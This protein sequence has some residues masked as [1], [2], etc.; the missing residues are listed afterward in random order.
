MTAQVSNVPAGTVI[1][2]RLEAEFHAVRK[3]DGNSRV[4]DGFWFGTVET[5]VPLLPSLKPVRVVCS[6]HDE[7]WGSYEISSMAVAPVSS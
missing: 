6:C 4:L 7:L 2:F 1:V 5:L 3:D